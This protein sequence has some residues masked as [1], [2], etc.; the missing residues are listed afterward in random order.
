MGFAEPA[1]RRALRE[2]YN[3]ENAAANRLLSG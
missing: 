1:V 3:D 2:C